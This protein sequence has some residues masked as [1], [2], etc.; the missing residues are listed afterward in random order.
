VTLPTAPIVVV[1]VESTCWRGTPPGGQQSEIIEVG[2]CLLDPATQAVSD[3]RSI[4]VKPERSRVSVF[5]T[6]LTTLTQAMVDEGVSFAAACET[7]VYDYESQSRLWVSWGNY[8]RE[9]FTR[10]C[11]SFGVP[12]PFGERHLNVKRVYGDVLNSGKQVGMAKALRLL[13][14]PLEGTHHRGDDDAYN[15][16]RLLGYMLA[17]R[18]ADVTAYLKQHS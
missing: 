10:Q 15:I 12:Y 7:L 4:L 8:D 9:M 16:A 3:K 14:M 17:E 2:V 13:E 1:D 11:A 5:C 6:K 18:S